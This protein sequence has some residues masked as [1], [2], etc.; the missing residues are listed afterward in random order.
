MQKVSD[1]AFHHLLDTK[2]PLA[3][4]IGSNAE[5]CQV[6]AGLLGKIVI[7]AAEKGV[8]INGVYMGE[9][10]ASGGGQFT[11]R[12]TFNYRPLTIPIGIEPKGSLED[13]LAN[14]GIQL[15]K[16]LAM[17]PSVGR[18]FESLT[19]KLVEY[20]KTK[21]VNFSELWVYNEGAF[22]SRDDEM[23]IKVGHGAKPYKL[24][25]TAD[26]RPPKHTRTDFS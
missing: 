2:T 14:K 7:M 3:R 18:L 16:V 21:G 11:S 12:I 4:V 8:P 15:A 24:K 22:I 6:L 26:G 9:L 13:Y 17:N 5:V 10:R 23:V 20:A 25:E 1:T 19:S